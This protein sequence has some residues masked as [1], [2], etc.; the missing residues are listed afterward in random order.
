V[1]LGT[2]ENARILLVDSD[3]VVCLLTKSYVFRPWCMIE[4]YEAIKAGKELKPVN[5]AN[6]GYDFER[7]LAVLTSAGDDL[8]DALD[9]VNLGAY[10]ALKREG[11]DPDDVCGTVGRTL[12]YLMAKP[13]DPS[14]TLNVKQAQISDMLGLNPA[15]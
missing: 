3:V 15:P 12:P 7:S 13:F 10:D 2:E 5:V 9:A 4:M 1:E 6:A 8:R 14:A 11:Y